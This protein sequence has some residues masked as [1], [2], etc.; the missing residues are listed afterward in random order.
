MT[1]EQ[2]HLVRDSF[3]RV[4]PMADAAA[5]LFYNRLF[6]LD[7]SLKALFRSD[8]E[9]QGRKLMQ[10]IAFVVKRLERP[11]EI[12]PVVA[13]LGARHRRYGVRPA[14][15]GTV[16]AALLWTLEHGLGDAFT[17]A[18]RA[19]WTEAYNVLATTMQTAEVENHVR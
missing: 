10:A 19:A 7:P 1:V 9:E 16:G 8:L 11:A 17:P 6:A 5:S 12:L 2:V 14:H 13:E 4:A 3:N 15:Y 18:V